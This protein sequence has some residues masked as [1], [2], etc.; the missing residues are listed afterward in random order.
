MDTGTKRIWF[1]VR[2]TIADGKTKPKEGNLTPQ[3]R[4]K[5][6]VKEL[7]AEDPEL[8]L[9]VPEFTRFR[10]ADLSQVAGWIAGH[11]LDCYDLVDF[12]REK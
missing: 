11:K 12:I 4:M 3:L 2:E 7:A 8:A 10:P 1:R 6:L 5:N 9:K